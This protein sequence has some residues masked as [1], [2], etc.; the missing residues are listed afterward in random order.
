[1]TDSAP[2]RPSWDDTWLRVARAVAERSLCERDKVGAVIVDPRNRIVATGY[3]G[4]PAG[5]TG[6]DGVLAWDP[7][8]CTEWC[9]RA[10]AAD[11]LWEM[12]VNPAIPPSELVVTS[13]TPYFSWR[14]HEVPATDE[15]LTRLGARKVPLDP[16][17][18]DCPS[19][20]AEANA[21]SVCDRSIRER[22]TLYVTSDI[23]W[24]CAKLVANSGLLRVVIDGV[25]PAVHR[26]PA[27]SREFMVSCGLA[28]TVV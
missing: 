14:G 18:S 5:F 1:M 9:P 28:V 2:P 13:E 8:P 11:H 24:N 25:R 21:L 3:N 23:C 17:Y 19:L 22:G 16:D 10:S 4:P 7:R 12:P 26:N 27:R 15:A 6:P 20:H